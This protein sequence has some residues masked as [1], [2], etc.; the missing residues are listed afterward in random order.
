[1]VR[2]STRSDG[3]TVCATGR[4]CAP[5]KTSL[6]PLAEP[7][8]RVKVSLSD[9]LADSLANEIRFRRPIGFGMK[10]TALVLTAVTLAEIERIF[11]VLERLGIS[12]EAVVIP[13]R[14]AVPGRVRRLP[15]GR[16][17]IIVDA[18]LPFEEWLVD[19]ERQLHAAAG[20]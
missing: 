4:G 2:A 14:P 1:M 11:D 5:A 8:L 3:V 12:R 13:L 17:E 15:N 16:F 9:Q 18:A 20:G 6:F 7:S 10:S 19:L